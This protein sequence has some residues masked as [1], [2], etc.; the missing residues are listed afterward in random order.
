MAYMSWTRLFVEY[1]DLI[2][3]NLVRSE[4]I[5]EGR[6]WGRWGQWGRGWGRCGRWG[7]G[8]FRY[9]LDP[10]SSRGSGGGGEG[11][12]GFGHVVERIQRSTAIQG[13]RG[14]NAWGR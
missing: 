9:A 14:E 11:G 13:C 8:G 12:A 3:F 7:G 10:P 6:G 4:T 1:I 5:R 2:I